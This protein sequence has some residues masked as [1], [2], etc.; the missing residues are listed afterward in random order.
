MFCGLI[1][2]GI[3]LLT[4]T[5]YKISSDHARYFEERNL[6]H[7]GILFTL[8]NLYSAFFGKFD[9]FGMMESLYNTFPEEP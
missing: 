7:R 8:N 4:Y 3:V 2:V 6:K 9:V 1:A 5:F